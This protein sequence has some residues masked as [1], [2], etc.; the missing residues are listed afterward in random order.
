[1]YDHGHPPPPAGQEPDAAAYMQGTSTVANV[2]RIIMGG[3]LQRGLVVGHAFLSPGYSIL[4]A[5]RDF[6]GKLLRFFHRNRWHLPLEIQEVSVQNN[7]Q[8]FNTV[9]ITMMKDGGLELANGAIVSNGEER[10]VLMENVARFISEGGSTVF[11]E[12]VVERPFES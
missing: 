7:V 6:Y 3:A 11:L 9:S 4:S 2:N 1:M 5:S 10:R 12:C 8:V